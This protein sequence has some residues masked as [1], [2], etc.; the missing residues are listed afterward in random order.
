MSRAVLAHTAGLETSVFRTS[1][2]TCSPN[3]SG[4]GG[5][6]LWIS[7]ATIHETWGRLLEATSVWNVPG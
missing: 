7:G 4:A 6:S 2:A 5:C 3:T 1:A